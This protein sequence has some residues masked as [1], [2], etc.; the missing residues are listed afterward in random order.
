ME[1][2]NIY[3]IDWFWGL[4]AC[5][6]IES[7]GLL[8]YLP[9]LC[10]ESFFMVTYSYILTGGIT[11]FVGCWILKKF[12]EFAFWRFLIYLVL[13]IAPGTLISSITTTLSRPVNF[14]PLRD[15]SFI[16]R[17]DPQWFLSLCAFVLFMS[18][19]TL[20]WRLLFNITLRRAFLAGA[21]AGL[22][23]T[24]TYLAITPV[25]K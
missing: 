10:R 21:I 12:K 13:I 2:N 17:S 3:W 5:I 20:S 8:L 22:L 9:T 19:N 4:L 24:I 18:L 16:F 23:N 7:F 11:F 1:K 25:F 15:S 6:A 14:S